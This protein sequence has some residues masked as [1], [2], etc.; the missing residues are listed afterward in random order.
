MFV[1]KSQLE[2]I[3][4][5]R[6]MFLVANGSLII[7]RNSAFKIMFDNLN[8]GHNCR[9]Q[10]LLPVISHSLLLVNAIY[11]ILQLNILQLL[12]LIKFSIT[13]KNIN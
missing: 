5:H 4:Y 9:A 1:F 6:V 7:L 3:E 13:I 8:N 12:I 10:S 11:I 2:T